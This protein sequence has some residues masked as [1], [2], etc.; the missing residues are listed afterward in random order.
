MLSLLYLLKTKHETIGNE[1][2]HLITLPRLVV[3]PFIQHQIKSN[4]KL[5]KKTVANKHS[6]TAVIKISWEIKRNNLK[7]RALC[8]VCKMYTTGS[9]ETIEI[10]QKETTEH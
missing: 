2:L 1:T 3:S 4:V 5:G 8:F 7:R 6:S 9:S 10:T